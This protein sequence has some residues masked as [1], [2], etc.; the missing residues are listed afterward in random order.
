MGKGGD[1]RPTDHLYN[2]VKKDAIVVREENW[3]TVKY[4]AGFS[5]LAVSKPLVNHTL[6]RASFLGIRVILPIPL[7]TRRKD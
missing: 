3:A 7:A 5:V 4:P 6:A 1:D 2:V